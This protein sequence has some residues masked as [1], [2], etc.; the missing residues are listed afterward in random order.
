MPV[1][2]AAVDLAERSRDRREADQLEHLAARHVLFAAPDAAG[3][4]LGGHRQVVGVAAREGR[5]RHP[6]G[7]LQVDLAEE[8]H[9]GRG[10]VA[11]GP[12]ELVACPV[13]GLHPSRSSP[14][15]AYAQ[16]S[17]AHSMATV[18]SQLASWAQIWPS[19]KNRNASRYGRG[20]GAPVPSGT[21]CSPP[22]RGR[23]RGGLFE[24]A[25]RCRRAAP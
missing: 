7:G 17:L 6:A 20:A 5:V 9:P 15:M 25:A 11:V 18:S 2:D 10:R 12:V 1:D 14:S 8:P 16:A 21:G 24:G 4:Q 23:G 13:D 3:Q 22:G 19:W